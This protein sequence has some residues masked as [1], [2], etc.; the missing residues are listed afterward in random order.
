MK[1]ELQIL[2]LF[3]LSIVALVFHHF[4][5]RKMEV[6]FRG[7]QWA[8]AN[9]YAGPESFANSRITD[10][11]AETKMHVA[12][13]NGNFTFCAAIFTPQERINL[14]LLYTSPSPRDKRQS[15]M[16]SSA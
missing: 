8:F 11:G 16:P 3:L 2:I 6:D 12:N 14:C 4:V 7:G 5:P 15:R 9:S 10:R 1:L 13:N